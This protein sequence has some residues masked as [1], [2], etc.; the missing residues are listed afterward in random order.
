MEYCYTGFMS[1]IIFRIQILKKYLRSTLTQDYLKS[2][3]FMARYRKIYFAK[4]T[5]NS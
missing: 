2:F 3:V 1:A 4:F 5:L